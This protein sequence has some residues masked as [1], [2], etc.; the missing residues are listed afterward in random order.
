MT[1]PDSCGGGRRSC[2]ELAK[3][4]EERRGG[5]AAPRRPMMRSLLVCRGRAWRSCRRTIRRPGSATSRAS[6]ARISAGCAMP[7]PTCIDPLLNAVGVPGAVELDAG[8]GGVRAGPVPA[9][10]VRGH[11]PHPSAV[12]PGLHRP[13]LHGHV[14]RGAVQLLGLPQ[15]AFMRAAFLILVGATTTHCSTRGGL[16]SQ[17]AVSDGASADRQ[18]RDGRVRPGLRR[19][20]L[21]IS[22]SGRGPSATRTRCCNASTRTPLMETPFVAMADGCYLARSLHLVAQGRARRHCT[23][24]PSVTGVGVLRRPGH[25]D[26]DVRPRATRPGRHRWCCTT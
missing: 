23:I 22:S 2:P 6:G 15:Q 8:A 12:R 19:R 10:P 1:S 18:R 21:P 11:V 20:A 14:H 17:T 13:G 4:G 7:T 16:A 5:A 9:L 3:A 24:L 25:R 26:R